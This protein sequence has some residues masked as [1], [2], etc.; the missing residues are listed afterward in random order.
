MVDEGS[1]LYL[2]NN[3]ARA[4]VP[5][6]KS[7]VRHANADRPIHLRL[8][9]SIES[10]N[11]AGGTG[12]WSQC[13]TRTSKIQQGTAQLVFISVSNYDTNST[14][15][16]QTTQRCP[17]YCQDPGSTNEAKSGAEPFYS[18]TLS[19][20]GSN[21]FNRNWISWWMRSKV[22]ALCSQNSGPLH[23]HLSSIMN[24][25]RSGSRI[26]ILVCMFMNMR[27]SRY[28]RLRCNSA[29]V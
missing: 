3:S 7:L 4:L 13:H 10:P 21:L 18:K 11:H 24:C 20:R 12:M 29:S 16:G 27:T 5:K 22:L 25:V 19:S 8:I 26:H 17:E 14:S 1:T 6:M 23:F 28:S 9:V 15:W 2:D